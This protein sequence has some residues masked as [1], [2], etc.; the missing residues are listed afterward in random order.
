LQLREE[1]LRE[2]RE[3]HALRSVS[4]KVETLN[5]PRFVNRSPWNVRHVK[6][7][8]ASAESELGG[9]RK[10]IRRKQTWSRCLC[11]IWR[12]WGYMRAM[13]RTLSS[14]AVGATPYK[15]VLHFRPCLSWELLPPRTK[16]RALLI[17]STPTAD[18]DL[19]T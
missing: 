10:Y 9:G 17:P 16:K 7:G 15:S 4:G 3:G 19:V 11:G 12:K 13:E 2:E 5:V 6:V 8:V 1:L 14:G 18:R